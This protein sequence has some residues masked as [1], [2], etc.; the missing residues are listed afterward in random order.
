MQQAAPIF[1]QIRA[2]FY[3]ALA[4]DLPHQHGDVTDKF[5]DGVVLS[6]YKTMA[7]ARV[8]AKAPQP[9]GMIS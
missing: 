9:Y 7:C 3:N 8:Q 4:N 2:P 1:P 5:H 6:P